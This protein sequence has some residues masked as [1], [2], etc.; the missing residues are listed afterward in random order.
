[1][2]Q[3]QMISSSPTHVN[4]LSYEGP[5]IDATL[6]KANIAMKKVLV[7]HGA[8]SKYFDLE[9]KSVGSVRKSLRES[10]NLPGDA[11][12]VIDGKTVGDDF[13]LEGGQTLDFTK[14]AGVKG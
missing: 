9:G 11:E 12:A 13:I 4:P 3:D 8:N 10:F 14:E 5:D 7:N 2:S 1:M 6:M